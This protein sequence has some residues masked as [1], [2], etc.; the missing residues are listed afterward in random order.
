VT[1]ITLQIANLLEADGEYWWEEWRPQGVLMTILHKLPD[2]LQNAMLL[3]V[4]N[5]R[6]VREVF[7]IV[8]GHSFVGLD[9]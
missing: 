7:R 5:L 9:Y 1:L 3:F 8:E 4:R 2:G 6:R